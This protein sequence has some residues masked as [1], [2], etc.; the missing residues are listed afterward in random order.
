MKKKS[1]IDYS[2]ISNILG[3]LVY[4]Q[5]TF[6]RKDLRFNYDTVNLVAVPN[7]FYERIV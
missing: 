7:E 1:L 3:W 4:Q 6:Y 5:C 2:Y